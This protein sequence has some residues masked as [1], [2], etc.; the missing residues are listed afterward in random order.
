MGVD[1]DTDTTHAELY[2]TPDIHM[3]RPQAH[4]AATSSVQTMLCVNAL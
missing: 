3:P 2:S 1:T 4:L